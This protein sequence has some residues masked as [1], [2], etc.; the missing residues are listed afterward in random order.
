MKELSPAPTL[1]SCET[2]HIRRRS[3]NTML[4]I[5]LKLACCAGAL[6]HANLHHHPPLPDLFNVTV[7]DIV[8]GFQT[9]QFTSADLVT[10]YIARISEV[11]EALRPVIEINPQAL[12]IAH[13]LDQERL[14]QNKTRGPLHGVPVLLKDNIGT[15]DELNTTAGSYALFGSIVPRDSTVARNLR[16]AGAVI[17]GKA[18]LSE[19]AYWRGSCP[20]GWSARGG[21][22][23]GAYFEDQDPGGSSSGSGV[24]AS[25]GLAPLTIGSDT[26]GS[27]ISP[28]GV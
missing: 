2:K 4:I 28:A 13:A 6:V 1:S 14:S 22:V 9:Q 12:E 24:A 5:A 19:W 7:D 21:Q 15:L 18:G 16:A 27:I 25:L 17:L 8:A 20:N 26:G 23:K 11:Q 3:S 10:A